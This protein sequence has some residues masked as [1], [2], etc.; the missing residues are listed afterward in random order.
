LVD[1]IRFSL[2]LPPELEY[3]RLVADGG[4]DRHAVTSDSAP[5][6]S[7]REITG[8][9]AD[10][11]LSVDTP[12]VAYLAPNFRSPVMADPA[13]RRALALATNA[14]GCVVAIGG[15]RAGAVAESIVNPTVLG[16]RPNPAFAG[17]DSGDP[18]AA[19][20]LLAGTGLDLPVPLLFSYGAGEAVDRCAAALKETW[21]RAGFDVTL[22]P[23]PSTSVDALERLDKD[24]DVVLG[25]W[26][27]DWPSAI[28]VTPPL[29]DSRQNITATTVGQD[30]GAYHSDRFNELVDEARRATE[31]D[32]QT[33]ALQ[34]ADLLLG[35][36][37]AYV[38]ISV[39]RFQLLHG[40]GVTGFVVTPAS[41]GVPD[42]G[43]IGVT[44]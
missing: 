44:G 36:D 41:S 20:R 6:A 15:Q 28:T 37:V 22:D 32:A 12:Y 29:F 34:R 18:E 24:S 13:V 7:Y 35:E 42:L 5:P 31:L 38:P 23:Q 43:P 25:Y 39:A 9:V 11:A 33:D 10:R 8:S 2:G 14:E 17:P 21:D 26:G 16:Y 19:Q 27:A 3:D 4:D 40:S 1:R 30:Y